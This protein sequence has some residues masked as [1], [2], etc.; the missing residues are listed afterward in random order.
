MSGRVEDFFAYARE[1][2]AIYLRRAA[3]APPPWTDDPVLQQ[4][5]FCNVFRELDSTTQW[6]RTN[7]REPLRERPE[8]L[9]ATVVFRLFNRIATGEA[10]FKQT[11]LFNSRKT[12]WEVFLAEGDKNILGAA[13]KAYC[14]SGPYTTGS[15]MTK[16]PT[17][18]NK[19]DGMLQVIEWFVKGE[20]SLP[21]MGSGAATFTWREVAEGCLS[22]GSWRHDPGALFGLQDVWAWLRQFPF[23][24]DFTAY[25]IV[26]DLRHTVLLD[27]APDIN[28]WANP[29]P[30]AKRGL[31]AMHGRPLKSGVRR[32][33]YIEEMMLLL[34]ASR[35]PSYWPK[36]VYDKGTDAFAGYSGG[37]SIGESD[38]PIWQ[39]DMWPAW[40]LREVEHTLCEFFKYERAR[41]TGQ[42]TRQ[43]F[44]G[45]V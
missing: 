44:R 27:H 22:N 12:V 18:M 3:G 28:T 34:E 38:G 8:V 29:G 30:G 13:I 20:Q 1:R 6:F 11:E 9:L 14:G 26:T 35:D 45:G 17:G 19:L 7:V 36:A 21:T 39:E 42:G 24:G 33:I 15:Y 37:F 25:E 4:Y 31:N 2:H 40:E 10:I 5:R 43:R 41:T 32:E 23:I 16:T